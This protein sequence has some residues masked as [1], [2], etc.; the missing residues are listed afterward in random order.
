MCIDNTEIGSIPPDLR[1]KCPTSNTFKTTS[2]WAGIPR[3]G[4]DE[5]A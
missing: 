2:S 3:R 5:P 1:P 4:A